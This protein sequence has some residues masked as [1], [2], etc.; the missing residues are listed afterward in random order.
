MRSAFGSAGS[1]SRSAGGLAAGLQQRNRYWIQFL[2]ERIAAL[3]GKMRASGDSGA[4]DAAAA[5]PAR[6]AGSA[7]APA[8]W[9]WPRADG[10]PP[11][12]DAEEA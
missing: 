4:P 7:P 3:E 2:D 12:P 5:P 9:G 6:A 1:L 8:A 10:A 11:D